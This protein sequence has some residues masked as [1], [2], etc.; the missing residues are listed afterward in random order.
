M[1]PFR[2]P[3]RELWIHH[4]VTPVTT[5]PLAD[6]RHV[7]A[8]AFGRGFSDISYNFGLHPHRA[9]VLE[10]RLLKWVGAH[11]E[12]RN[13]ISF[14]VVLI[15][16]YENQKPTRGQIDSFRWLRH[17]LVA[18]GVLTRDHRLGYHQQTKPTACPGRNVVASFREFA[19]PWV[20]APVTARRPQ[21]MYL[22]QTRAGHI[23]LVEEK[24]VHV[25]DPAVVDSAVRQGVP[26]LPV[27]DST[28]KNLVAAKGQ[29]VIG[30]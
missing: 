4:S 9:E 25:P 3:A 22:V 12:G 30:A 21:R 1:A 23:F 6:W 27:D 28:W 8:V 15:G 19:Q 13:S 29:P 16:N 26:L 20:S 18:R 10:G 14:G 5:D 7:Q 17:E 2:F 24:I 11:T